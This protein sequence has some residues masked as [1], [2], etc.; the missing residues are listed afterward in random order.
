VTAP[1]EASRR[2]PP[3]DRAPPLGA[4]LPGSF[5]QVGLGLGALGY[6]I[7]GAY[8]QALVSSGWDEIVVAVVLAGAF[9]L[10]FRRPVAGGWI[11]LAVVYAEL[12]KS[13]ADVGAATS[14]TLVM[15]LLVTCAGLFLGEGA[16]I[17]AGVLGA[18]GPAI[19]AF[20]FGPPLGSGDLGAARTIQRLIVLALTCGVSALLIRAAVRGYRRAL[21]SSDR[22]RRRFLDL[23]HRAPDGLIALEPGGLVAEANGR[24]EAML[25]AG[26]LRGRPIREVMDA[27]GAHATRPLEEGRSEAPAIVEV[28]TGHA[29]R[30]FEVIARAGEEG[31]SLLVLRETTERRALEEQLLHAQRLETVGLLAG[32]VAHDFNNL[33]TAIGGNA[34]VLGDDERPEVRELAREIVDAQRR[35]SALTRQLLAFAR[36]DQRRPERMDLGLAVRGMERLLA[37]LL[38]EKHPLVLGAQGDVP[39]VADQAQV[40]QV[41][42][43]LVTNARDA[44]PP[45][46]E[47]AVAVRALA[48]DEARALGCT[49]GGE[50]AVLEVADRGAGMSPET[51]ARIFEPFFTTKAR[52]QGTGLGLSTVHGIVAQSGGQISIDTAPG[53]GSTFR[54]FL[55]LA[56]GAA[57]QE[58]PALTPVPSAGTGERI[59]VVEDDPGVR[60]LVE[61]VLRASGYVVSGFGSGAAA[62]ESLPAD[63]PLHLLVTDMAMPGMDGPEV[64]R[65]V[66]DRFP[67]VPVLFMT[68]YFEADEAQAP[69]PTLLRKPFT[70]EEL[71]GR[72]RDALLGR[73]AA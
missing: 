10:S 71:L 51:R 21:E 72:V 73:R 28:G 26:D 64:A 47:V 48:R 1:A 15:P 44:S 67:G 33:L 9:A 17:W 32:G 50:V 24:A 70:P 30:T 34:E 12:V 20:G 56:E 38:A 31:R 41:V 45:G 66:R 23:F 43:N 16:A 36:R 19:A 68:G 4:R 63:R 35:G 25:G 40:E 6:A 7:V 42:V 53:R 57:S 69:D 14:A 54:V 55:P 37:R 65:R 3:A 61:R 13:F 58:R 39:V 8:D 46:T 5:V 18:A 29:A 52:G 2:R 59:L 27:V 22:E 11:G 49:L 60:A 62:V